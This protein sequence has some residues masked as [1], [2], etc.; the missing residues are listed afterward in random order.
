MSAPMKCC[1]DRSNLDVVP[2]DRLTI[3]R[4]NERG[5]TPGL[6]VCRVCGRKHYT[7]AVRPM[8]FGVT[9]RSLNGAS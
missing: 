5:G 9:G 7:L 4:A 2:L 1:Q 8:E 6:L 3:K